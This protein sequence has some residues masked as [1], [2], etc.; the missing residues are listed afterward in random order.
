MK[1]K[2]EFNVNFKFG[3]RNTNFSI[4]KKK[5]ILCPYANLCKLWGGT[6]IMA[7]YYA[8]PSKDESDILWHCLHRN[9]QRQVPMDPIL[10]EISYLSCP[11]YTR[12]YTEFLNPLSSLFLYKSFARLTINKAWFLRC[13]TP[14]GWYVRQKWRKTPER[15]R[16]LNQNNVDKR[17]R[18]WCTA[19]C[20]EFMWCN[21]VR[22]YGE[23]KCVLSKIQSLKF[24]FRR[25]LRV[26]YSMLISFSQGLQSEILG[27]ILAFNHHLWVS[28]KP[29]NFAPCGRRYAK[30]SLCPESVSYQEKDA[31]KSFWY[32]SGH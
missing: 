19:Y 23:N 2:Q 18:I 29:S 26:S 14:C 5:V 3:F 20:I 1:W 24:G 17:F 25:T 7:F 4:A 15:C 10:A 22:N 12:W 31:C 27:E 8:E 32:E 16:I 9:H 28:Q 30:G 13:S 6:T 11:L 21:R